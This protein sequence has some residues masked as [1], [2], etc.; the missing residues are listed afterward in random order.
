MAPFD[1]RS[2]DLVAQLRPDLGGAVGKLTWRGTDLLRPAAPEETSVRKT[3]SFPMV[4]FSGRI[5]Y[6]RFTHGGREYQLVPNF[7]DEPHSVHGDAWLNKWTIANK[8]AD[9]ATLTY[10][11]PAGGPGAKW[12]LTYRT[13]QRFKVEPDRLT[14][15]IAVTNTSQESFPA[16]IGFH[17]YF[18]ARPGATVQAGV[19]QV[20]TT[21]KAGVPVERKAIPP[22]W[23]FRKARLVDDIQVDHCF[24]SW[25]GKA[26]LDYPSEGFALEITGSPVFSHLVVYVPKGRGYFC[27]EPASHA[28]DVV[29]REIPDQGFRVLKP[30]EKLEGSFGI[31]VRASGV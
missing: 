14:I 12:P 19:E 1:I 22:E 7:N 10:D 3:G 29:H 8:A 6:A 9:T 2:G 5:A 21:D 20:W 27:V 26:R 18:V 30:G 25:N 16:G 31:R 23:D 15:D 11:H 4:P 24:T 13:E 17:P 28:T